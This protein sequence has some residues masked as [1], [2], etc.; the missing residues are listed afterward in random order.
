MIEHHKFIISA[1]NLNRDEVFSVIAKPADDVTEQL[2][3]LTSTVCQSKDFNTDDQ[4][5]LCNGEHNPPVGYHMR[6]VGLDHVPSDDWLCPGC[7]KDE[8]YIIKSVH[9]KRTRQQKV[10]YLVARALGGFW[11]R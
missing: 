1:L 7:V 3:Q 11:I 2:E 4:I 5:I 6:C 8:K 10:E 9:A